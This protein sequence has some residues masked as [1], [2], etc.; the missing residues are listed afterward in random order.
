[1]QVKLSGENM[2][3]FIAAAP[4]AFDPPGR[5]AGINALVGAVNAANKYALLCF[6]LFVVQVGRPFLA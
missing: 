3:L 4:D 2:K 6:L 5:E 1:M